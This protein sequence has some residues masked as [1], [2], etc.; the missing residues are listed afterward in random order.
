M[1]NWGK[2]ETIM[3]TFIRKILWRFGYD[4]Q[5]HENSGGSLRLAYDLAK[6]TGFT[7]L[8]DIGANQGQSALEFISFFPDSKIIS[9]EP[10]SQAH[11]EIKRRSNAYPHWSVF[12]RVAVGEAAGSTEI[13]VS[14]NSVS[15]SLLEM[16]STHTEVAPHSVMVGRESVPIVSLNEVLGSS[17]RSERYYLKI[18]TQGYELKVLKGADKILD[19]VV[20]IQVELSWVELYAGQPLALE[21]IQWLLDRGFSPFGFAPGLR[22]TDN[23]QLLQMDGFFLRTKG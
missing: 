10:L 13:H 8:L 4:L 3:K 20:A 5:K 2:I 1:Q 17:P 19:Q 16:K 12:D 11:E 15:S 23:R 7:T 9:F 22:K 6:S 21:V 14:Q 18:D